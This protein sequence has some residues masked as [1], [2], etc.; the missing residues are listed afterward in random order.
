MIELKKLTFIYGSI[1]SAVAQDVLT[2]QDIMNLKTCSQPQIS[3]DGKWI[4]FTSDRAGGDNIWI[5]KRDGASPQQ[6][7]KEDFNKKYK[8]FEEMEVG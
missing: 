5:I 6:V 1:N 7:T 3:P 4:A 2:A 8:S